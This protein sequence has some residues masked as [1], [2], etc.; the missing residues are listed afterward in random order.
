MLVCMIVI[1][2]I[3]FS[4][5]KKKSMEKL[6]KE[7]RNNAGTYNVPTQ[8]QPQN[9]HPVVGTPAPPVGT[10]LADISKQGQEQEQQG[11]TMVGGV[12][13]GEDE[14]VV[15]TIGVEPFTDARGREVVR[16]GVGILTDK[17]FYYKG[18]HHGF[19]EAWGILGKSKNIESGRVAIKDVLSTHTL[20]TL[21]K[22]RNKVNIMES[23]LALVIWIP[24][25]LI[26]FV[27]LAIIGNIAI[28]VTGR[29]PPYP[30]PWDTL[31][32]G[33]IVLGAIYGVGILFR[34]L[35]C[36]VTGN[37]FRYK[38]Q[39]YSLFT[40][41]FRGSSF[42][43]NANLYSVQEIQEFQN[44]LKLLQSSPGYM[45]GDLVVG[46]DEKIISTIGIANSNGGNQL[47]PNGY[48]VLTDKHFY[49]TGNLLRKPLVREQGRISITD[50][51]SASIK[52]TSAFSEIDKT[53][54]GSSLLLF[55]IAGLLMHPAAALLF[56]V[57]YG[58]PCL[59]YYF[60]KMRQ[61]CV[62][63]F[64]SGEFIFDGRLFSPTE[65]RE[66]QNGFNLLKQQKAQK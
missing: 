29:R 58:L 20:G 27:G 41:V 31:I 19:I 33:I 8:T 43:Y 62:V 32:A 61:A 28:E 3:M 54:C 65:L 1:C 10:P 60:C 49:Y 25:I 13:V 7:R 66:F 57:A 35:Y 9:T 40:V 14:Q 12:L 16:D 30:A 6:E 59:L 22:R 24:I 37:P 26:M 2:F 34:L 15:A 46:Q 39:G 50:I 4:H 51:L 56:I 38:A 42:G 48:G 21:N 55:A 11:G 36:I 23:I 18:I 53:I 63:T 47:N 44:Q 5:S 45:Y 17:Y 64:R 52:K